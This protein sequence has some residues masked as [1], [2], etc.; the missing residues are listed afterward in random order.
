MN[1]LQIQRAPEELLNSSE[2]LM[3]DVTAEFDPIIGLKLTALIKQL[4]N[5]AYLMGHED[6]HRWTK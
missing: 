3:L 5:V 4:V 1:Q 6:G 2:H